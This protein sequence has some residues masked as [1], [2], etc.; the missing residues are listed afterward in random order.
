MLNLHCFFI[1]LMIHI[2]SFYH[3]QKGKGFLKSRPVWPCGAA[4]R[5]ELI[6]VS[7][8]STK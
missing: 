2:I 7:I 6:P 4:V 8:D 3:D 1:Q 5:L